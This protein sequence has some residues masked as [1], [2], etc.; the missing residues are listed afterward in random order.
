MSHVADGTQK[1]GHDSFRSMG[2]N[3]PVTQVVR[4]QIVKI[5]RRNLIKC[6]TARSTVITVRT[7]IELKGSNSNPPHSLTPYIDIYTITNSRE[8]VKLQQICFQG[9]CIFPVFKNKKTFGRHFF[10][11]WFA[12]VYKRPIQFF[13]TCVSEVIMF[14]PCGFV[15]LWLCVFITMFVRMI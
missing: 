12:E 11:V 7:S 1:A 3:S 8:P 13:I 5:P 6:A 2:W 9:S 4:F 15:C 14:S 10:T